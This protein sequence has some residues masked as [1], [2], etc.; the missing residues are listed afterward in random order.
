LLGLVA[1][2]AYALELRDQALTA[3]Q[4]FGTSAAPLRALARFIVERRN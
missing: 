3:L 2:K 4:T 1:A